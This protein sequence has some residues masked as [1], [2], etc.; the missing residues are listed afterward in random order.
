MKSVALSVHFKPLKSMLKGVLPAMVEPS[1]LPSM[2]L[3]MGFLVLSVAK[4]WDLVS[5]MLDKGVCAGGNVPAI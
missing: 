2:S 4:Y 3:K 5:Y 1:F